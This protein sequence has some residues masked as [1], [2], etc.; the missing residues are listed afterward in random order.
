MA[1]VILNLL[2]HIYLCMI[3]FFIIIETSALRSLKE[4]Q[5]YMKLIVYRCFMNWVFYKILQNKQ[6]RKHLDRSLFDNNVTAPYT[7]PCL[8][9]QSSLCK[10]FAEA[11]AKSLYRWP[12]D[13]IGFKNLR[14]PSPFWNYFQ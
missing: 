14:K 5:L 3:P 12:G 9:F 4:T 8:L 1:S 11:L 2:Y 7:Y 10:I 6:V 13:I